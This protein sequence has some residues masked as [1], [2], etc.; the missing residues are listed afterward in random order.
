M[1]DEVAEDLFGHSLEEH[2]DEFAPL[3]ARMRPRTLD[4]FVG[5]SAVAGSKSALRSLITTDRLSSMILWGPPGTG[6]TTLAEIVAQM[7]DSRF[8]RL[9]AVSASVSDMREAIFAAK[10]ALA[11]NGRRTILFIDEVHRFNKAQQ[12]TLLPAVEN[13]YVT[14]VGATTENPFFEINSP[15]MSRCLLFRLESLSDEDIRTI[16][17]RALSDQRGLGEATEIDAAALDAIVA[18]SGGD[19]RQALN[20]LEAAAAAA[21]ATGAS[22]ITAEIVTEA[23]RQQVTRYDKKGD[24]HYDVISAF[25]KSLRGSDP[26]AAVW[27]LAQMLEAGEDARFIARRMVIFASEDVGNADPNALTVAVGAFQA[28]EFVGLPE[29]SLNLAQAAI[30]LASAPKSN[31]S[32]AAIWRATGD[33]KSGAGGEVPIHLRDPGHPG[34][35]R[36]TGHGKGYEYPHDHP[37]GWIDQSYLPEGL[38][39]RVYYEPTDRGAEKEIG[40][41]L[42][43][44]RSNREKPPTG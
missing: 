13:G 40:E 8:V 12:D 27:W 44:L 34:A 38:E 4:E 32:A 20:S 35:A 3:A 10:H 23:L 1:L 22:S 5:Q 7:T 17:E 31:A 28:L 24:R 26:D 30:Y 36:R 2:F 9:S 37:E 25:I 16:L 14:L 18:R 15:L 11:A 29:A 33:I 39:G 21:A 19:A 42:K 43:R 41:R 6:K